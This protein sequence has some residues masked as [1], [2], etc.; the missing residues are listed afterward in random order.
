MI[1]VVPTRPFADQQPGTS[2]LRKK[3]KVFQQPNYAENFIQSVFDVVPG[4]E[5][6]TL[7]ARYAKLRHDGAEYNVSV[8]LRFMLDSDGVVCE[9]QLQNNSDLAIEEFWFPWVGP[10][11]GL[12]ADPVR[13]TL[14]LS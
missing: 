2:G 5:G 11:R 4:K 8:E 14:I 7:V 12:A 10:F 3:V 6:A 9:A 13:D 1:E